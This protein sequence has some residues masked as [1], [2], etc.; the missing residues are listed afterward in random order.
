MDINES[1]EKKLHMAG[2][3]IRAAGDALAVSG[4]HLET[5]SM[6][7]DP[8]TEDG[9]EESSPADY[10]TGQERKAWEHLTE[11]ER[12]QFE[13]QGE[14][15]AGRNRSDQV[16]EYDSDVDSTFQGDPDASGSM[17]TNR[18]PGSER[19]GGTGYTDGK[20]S[21]R[22]AGST[23]PSNG[24]RT[25]SAAGNGSTPWIGGMQKTGTAAGAESVQGVQEFLTMGIPQAA[26]SAWMPGTAA[27]TAAGTAASTAGGIAGG[28]AT[29]AADVA[30]KTAELFREHLMETAM[31]SGDA[32][33]QGKEG[34]AGVGMMPGM[35]QTVAATASAALAAVFAAAYAAAASVLS[36]LLGVLVAVLVPLLAVVCVVVSLVTAFGALGNTQPAVGSTQIV[37]VALEQ[38]GNDG[39]VYWDYVMGSAYI[40]GEQTPWCACFVSWCANECGYIDSGIF[41]KSGSVASYKNFY[42]SRGLYHEGDYEPKP[43]DLI[44]FEGN[45][46]IGIVQYVEGGR[47]ITIEGNA[48]NAVHTR[49]YSLGNGRISGYCTPEYPMTVELSEGSNAR[50]AYDFFRGKG[51]SP[52]ASSAIVANLMQESGVE[53]TREQE[54]GPGRGICQWEGARL[55]RLKEY[56]HSQGRGWYELNVQLEFLW[57]E[58]NG[59]ESTCQYIM[60]RDYGGLLNFMAATDL[61]WA[62]E[63]FERSFERAGTPMMEKRIQYAW[64]IYSQMER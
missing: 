49:S 11:H 21:M 39:R 42:Q 6:G 54:G 26:H 28:P 22:G 9:E 15:L 1:K 2:L 14:R 4:S 32:Q 5:L 30:K 19:T 56:A 25:S 63:A 48:S 29:A 36:A 50:V 40:D 47:V 35:M 44:I 24:A 37:Q 57:D 13:E 58:L 62:V 20:G 33:P 55:E 64:E 23:E 52:A 12:K 34:G 46:H 59:G 60:N 3:S 45:A 53:P 38:E 27:S 18:A 43:G 41:P 7:N 17:E 16:W 31:S 10:M 8:R 61:E 51:C